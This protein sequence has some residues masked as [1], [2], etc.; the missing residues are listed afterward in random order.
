MLPFLY[1]ISEF[2]I[3]YLGKSCRGK[4]NDDSTVV[5]KSRN[6]NGLDI[7]TVLKMVE[8]FLLKYEADS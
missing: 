3:A 1:C 2:K 8:G 7:G 6:N 5:T 4:T